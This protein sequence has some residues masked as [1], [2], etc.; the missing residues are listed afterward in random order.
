MASEPKCEPGGSSSGRAEG[1]RRR[2]GLRPRATPARV[3][4]YLTGDPLTFFIVGS[5]ATS[6]GVNS[7][8][9]GPRW[10]LGNNLSGRCRV[11]KAIPCLWNRNVRLEY[12]A[13]NRA[14]GTEMERWADCYQ[15]VQ[16]PNPTS[17]IPT[18]TSWFQT[19]DLSLLLLLF[20]FFICLVFFLLL[21]IFCKFYVWVLV[22]LCTN[23]VE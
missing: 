23:V 3:H 6:R 12:E 5:E 11:I 4:F 18:T 16:E 17:E 14:D 20:F 13:V 19:I 15:R 7:R 9:P 10:S 21:V 1:P 8:V 22:F 2:H